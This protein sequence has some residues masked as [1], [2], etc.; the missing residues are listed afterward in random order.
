ME[1]ISK[2]DKEE[3]ISRI[4]KE[5]EKIG[6]VLIVGAGTSGIQAAFDLV[7][8]GYKVYL[9]EKSWAL[10]GKMAQLDE[11][12]PTLDC[13]FCAIAPKPL[14]CLRNFDVETMA[15]DDSLV[16]ISEKRMCRATIVRKPHYIDG[17][18]FNL[19]ILSSVEVSRV[20][21][22]PGN[23]EVALYKTP[24]FVDI[25]KCTGCGK[26]AE[27]CPVNIPS[28]YDA[29]LT[30][31]K[32]IY[33][34]YPQIMKNIYRIDKIDLKEEVKK[35]NLDIDI[36]SCLS[37]RKCE[38]I[39]P[40]GAIN[41]DAVPEMQYINVG[42][43]ILAQGFEL[44]DPYTITELGFGRFKNVVTSLQLER[45]MTK[46]GPS[47][48]KLVR[49]SDSRKPEKIGFIQCVGTRN[50]KH[51]Y[52]S[53]VCCMHATKEAI[54]AKKRVPEIETKIF[55]LDMRAYS[56]GC[57]ELYKKAE[58]TYQVKYIRSRPSFIEEDIK[59]KDL[60]VTYVDEDGR[61][62]KENFGMICLSMG[63]VPPQTTKRD[64]Q[65]YQIELNEYGFIK[66]T[67]FK[68]LNTS[69]DGIFVCGSFSEP[70]DIPD[71]ITEGSGA[72]ALVS[73]LLVDQRGSLMEK[74]RYPPRMEIDY[75]N[76]RIGVIL[77]HCG[78]E[79]SKV[80]KMAELV[81][82]TRTIPNVVV[83]ENEFYACSPQIERKIEYLITQYNLN[84]L[85][86][87]ACSPRTH[88]PLFQEIL[89]DIGINHNMVEVVNLREQCS[90]VHYNSPYKAT[91]KAMSLI[92]MAIAKVKKAKPILESYFGINP[93]AL[94]IGGG[95][96][97]M[98]TSIN[99]AEQ[100][101]P[102]TL[103]EKESELGG[104]LR[105]IVFTL[106]GDDPQKLLEDL[107]NKINS[108]INIEVLIN[109]EVKDV[110]GYVGNFQSKIVIKKPKEKDEKFGEKNETRTI[111]HGVTIIA[112]G[113]DEY[114]G[115]EYLL[116]E[117]SQVMT[118]V[119]FEQKLI[120]SW[121]ELQEVEKLAMIQCVGCRNEERTYCSRVCCGKALKNAIK[122]KE[123]N[124]NA[125]IFIFYKDIRSYGFIEQ[126]YTKAREMGIIFIRYDDDKK[127]EVIRFSKK[128]KLKNDK[129]RL[130][131]KFFDFNLKKNFEIDVDKI[132][133]STAIIPPEG[134][135]KL[136]NI[137]DVP[138]DENG[139]FLEK[140]LKVRP[141]DTRRDGIFIC[142]LAH[143]PK[144]LR[145]T[146]S[147]SLATASRASTVLSKKEMKVGV[148]ICK[149]DKEK[150]IGCLTCLRVCPSNI[151]KINEEGISEI[152][153]FECMGCGICA[154]A[155]PAGAIEVIYLPY[156]QMISTELSLRGEVLV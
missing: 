13:F 40:E 107:R 124:P 102:V 7:E 5:L 67:E 64:S 152:N 17:K 156:D 73:A 22:Y 78:N 44:I 48:G 34:P 49:L 114:R 145:E 91:Q 84:R 118:Q 149:V 155:C 98:L 101:Y 57:E 3:D 62:I 128:K 109:S 12:Y 69:R 71:S 99:L 89:R 76:P 47:E 80:V 130:K 147:Q 105:K 122:F 59:T 29:S 15:F 66:T 137:L 87:A 92:Q 65:I 150:C 115:N 116:N 142:G 121:D 93:R 53:T 10:G 51:N 56:K 111:V 25:N 85:V 26:C 8:S 42:A 82:F 104:H 61:L 58:D 70:K 16:D 97:G 39:C 36:K 63:F 141:V 14:G 96:A 21:G 27:V 30:E 126:Y 75:E 144:Y 135:K 54:L 103:V 86:I 1:D 20:R 6:S 108:N 28:E 119:D 138:L 32:I 18:H 24:N 136:A 11:T 2:I 43:I 110:K 33:R 117:D 120:D 72:A 74:K 131:I 154:S 83:V 125:D 132:V 68:P 134:N 37:C 106:S 100:G 46:S 79:I 129:K 88:A 77:C 9:I 35:Y 113:A 60:I 139:F 95:I 4:S 38:E 81:K 127:P 143:S 151:P 123:K 41:F 90:W 19:E 55:T 146:I 50:K 23:F 133:L 94:V 45:I 52:C 31:R 148:K 112:T 140:H 153:P